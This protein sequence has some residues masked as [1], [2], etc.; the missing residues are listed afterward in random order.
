MWDNKIYNKINSIQ[1]K[2]PIAVKSMHALI[3]SDLRTACKYKRQM[4]LWR[5]FAFN[6][7]KMIQNKRITV[8]I[9]FIF[10]GISF[11]VF[12]HKK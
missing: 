3:M 5:F 8:L 4:T 1:I 2:I 11:F 12:L 10:M 6:I 7:I 9:K